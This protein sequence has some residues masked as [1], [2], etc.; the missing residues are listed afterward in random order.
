M[1]THRLDLPALIGSRICHDLISPLGAIGNGIELLAMT[2]EAPGPEME[3]ITESVENANA[4]IRFFRVAFGTSSEDQTLSRA[5]VASIL[6]A[7]ARGGRLSYFWDVE[8]DQ[9]RRDVRVVFLMLQCL[10]TAMPF[11]GDITVSRQGERWTVRAEA[12]RL[13]V[14]ADLW[15]SLT[16]SRQ[17]AQISAANVQFALLPQVL[18]QMSRTMTVNL[19]EASITLTF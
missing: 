12:A 2:G 9:P 8:G 19:A 7:A 13:K 18:T 4:R 1:S 16:N 15:A 14:D 5:D 6:K 3:L 11:G 10:E 17:R